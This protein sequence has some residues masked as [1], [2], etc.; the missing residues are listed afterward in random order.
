[1]ALSYLILYLS[2]TGRGHCRLCA[3][4]CPTPLLL[5]HLLLRWVI[6]VCPSALFMSSTAQLPR[7]V[8]PPLLLR[9]LPPGHLTSSAPPSR[10]DLHCPIALLHVPPPPIVS[11]TTQLP[12]IIRHP[13]ISPFTIASPL[14]IAVHTVPTTTVV[15]SI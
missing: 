6:G 8:N 10:C 15:A 5:C 3:S 9:P 14:S 7:I 13:I 1:M 11:S 2:Y 12:C 4:S